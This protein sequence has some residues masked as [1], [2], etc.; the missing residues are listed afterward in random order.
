MEYQTNAYLQDQLCVNFKKNPRNDIGM[1]KGGTVLFYWYSYLQFEKKEDLEQCADHL[2]ELLE[3]VNSALQHPTSFIF[4]ELTEV[5][6]LLSFLDLQ[7]LQR[8]PAIDTLYKDLEA[9]MRKTASKFIA[10]ENLDP[11]SGGGYVFNYFA[12]RND[13]SA[14]DAFILFIKEKSFL[15]SR[16]RKVLSLKKGDEV[17]LGITHGLAF[18][19]LF[20]SKTSAAT[21]QNTG[22][23]LRSFCKTVA[24]EMRTIPQEGSFFSDYLNDRTKASK[25]SLCYGDLGIFYSL[26]KAYDMLGDEQ[27]TKELAP[28]MIVVTERLT[29]YFD[30]T[31]DTSLLYGSGGVLLLLYFLKPYAQ[32][33]ELNALYE[34]QF[35]VYKQKV[36]QTLDAHCNSNKPLTKKELS[37]SEGLTGSLIFLMGLEQNDLAFAK[38]FYLGH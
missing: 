36:L 16:N 12:D 18:I 19:I 11:Y 3:A 32:L 17:Q 37:F 20:L 4:V 35:G 8:I 21:G 10:A 30:N 29:E 38:L 9:I 23:L 6:Y 28:F 7:Q 25:L 24:S 15:D 13:T 27:K 34:K 5:C 26:Y 33:P 31:E 14:I 1:G 22:S 2:S